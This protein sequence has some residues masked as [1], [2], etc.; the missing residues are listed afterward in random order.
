M[1]LRRRRSDGKGCAGLERVVRQGEAEGG[2]LTWRVWRMPG[3]DVAGSWETA[4]LLEVRVGVRGWH[5]DNMD[6]VCMV[7]DVHIVE[8]ATINLQLFYSLFAS[9]IFQEGRKV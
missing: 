1:S 9:M 2:H 8:Y 7:Q 4:E 3:P 6:D 5:N